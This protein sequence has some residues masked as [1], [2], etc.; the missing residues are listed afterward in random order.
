M[1]DFVLQWNIVGTIEERSGQ[2]GH[3]GGNE[4]YVSVRDVASLTSIS[5]FLATLFTWADIL[6]IVS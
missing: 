3:S 6:K 5:L 2:R 4:M 1:L